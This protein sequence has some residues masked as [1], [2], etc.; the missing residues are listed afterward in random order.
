MRLLAVLCGRVSPFCFVIPDL[1][2]SLALG[3]NL[4]V[5]L[6]LIRDAEVIARAANLVIR[7]TSNAN[8]IAALDNRF[9]ED[10]GRQT[11]VQRSIFMSTA[12]IVLGQTPHSVAECLCNFESGDAAKKLAATAR[13]PPRGNHRHEK[14]ASRSTVAPARG[15]GLWNCSTASS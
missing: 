2:Q 13:P 7:T 8:R 5:I 15:Y 11:S 6:D 3:F 12:L 10:S 14:Q 4:P 9:T 1:I